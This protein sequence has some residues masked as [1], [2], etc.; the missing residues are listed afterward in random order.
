MLLAA[1]GGQQALAASPS[2]ARRPAEH[3]E[4]GEGSLPPAL[5]ALE[6]EAEDAY[7]YAL[8]GQVSRVAAEAHGMTE[9]WRAFRARAASAGASEVVLD[10]MDAAVR[11]LEESAHQGVDPV[12][13]ARVT[14]ALS[15]PMADLFGLYDTAVP[16]AVL[17]L[18]YLGREVALDARQ[19]KFNDAGVHLHRLELVFS[20]VGD[21]ALEQHGQREVADFQ[22]SIDGMRAAIVA[23]DAARL[24]TAATSE[25]ELVDGLERVFGRSQGIQ[26]SEAEDDD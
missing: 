14:N 13:L 20:S 24:E 22:A 19:G 21:A 12:V 7:D 11:G 4:H 8:D 6:S 1:C 16:S 18:D 2:P 9:R 23:R 26:D 25:L 15:A 5:D 10:Q 17:E 3:T